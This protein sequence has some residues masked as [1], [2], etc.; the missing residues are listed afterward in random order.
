MDTS[1]EG[2]NSTHYWEL[3]LNAWKG[4][5]RQDGAG[6]A[7]PLRREERTLGVFLKARAPR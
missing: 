6:A 4:E 1:F 2:R 7:L 5:A 3:G